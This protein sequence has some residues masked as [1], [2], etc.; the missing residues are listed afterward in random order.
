M[1]PL[2]LYDLFITTEQWKLSSNKILGYIKK[3]SS[4]RELIM[5]EAY[6]PYLTLWNKI[7][8]NLA[9]LKADSHKIFKSHRIIRPSYNTFYKEIII[10]YT[11]LCLSQASYI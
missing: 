5:Y 10:K 1:D 8:Q 3:E 4:E 7:S 6:M 11:L 9:L 2:F